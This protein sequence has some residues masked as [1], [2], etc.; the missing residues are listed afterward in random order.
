MKAVMVNSQGSF[1]DILIQEIPK[2]LKEYPEWLDYI[3]RLYHKRFEELL[4][5]INAIAFK[6]AG[7]RLLLLLNKK[8]ELINSKTIVA[9][10]EQ[11]QLKISMEYIGCCAGNVCSTNNRSTFKN[12]KKIEY[13]EVV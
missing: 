12:E 10:H 13:E 8:S 5:V 3:F 9:T 1:D 4:E 11:M 6:K 7:E 2:P